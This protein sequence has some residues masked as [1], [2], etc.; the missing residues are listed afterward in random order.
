MADHLLMRDFSAIRRE[1]Y[2]SVREI[3]KSV[4]SK[5][6]AGF[7]FGTNTRY[8]LVL[9]VREACDGDYWTTHMPAVF[10]VLWV[11]RNAGAMFHDWG[12]AA[13]CALED[14]VLDALKE[15]GYDL[16]HPVPLDE[17]NGMEEEAE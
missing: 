13:A 17:G 4:A 12:M 5:I 7:D 8:N 3:A 1:Y 9:I 2:A 6:E 11:S 10:A 15:M 14:D 16:N